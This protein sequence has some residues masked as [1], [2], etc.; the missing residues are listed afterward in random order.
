MSPD[1]YINKKG[2][3]QVAVS[4]SHSQRLEFGNYDVYKNRV[5]TYGCVLLVNNHLKPMKCENLFLIIHKSFFSF[6][7]LAIQKFYS[8]QFMLVCLIKQ[9]FAFD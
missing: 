1:R 9:N 4:E 8:S 2:N 3:N 6:Q 5:Q 7:S